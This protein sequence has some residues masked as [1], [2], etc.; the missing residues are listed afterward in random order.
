MKYEFFT[1][2]KVIFIPDRKQY[3]ITVSL[4]RDG[5]TFFLTQPNKT[6]YFPT[7]TSGH[8]EFIPGNYGKDG[9]FNCNVK[10]VVSGLT[11]EMTINAEKKGDRFELATQAK[12]APDSR[13]IDFVFRYSLEAWKSKTLFARLFSEWLTFGTFLK[14]F[15]KI[16][17]MMLL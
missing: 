1:S 4:E 11:R 5:V 15:K 13:P 3:D 7:L 2:F 17:E 10:A 8:C 16:V 6:R 12:L 9:R 14:L